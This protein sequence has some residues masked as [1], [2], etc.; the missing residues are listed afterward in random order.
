[1]IYKWYI[2]MLQ[3]EGEVN[4]TDKGGLYNHEIP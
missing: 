4:G 2:E 3:E 1:M